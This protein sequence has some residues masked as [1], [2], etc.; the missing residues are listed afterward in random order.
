MIIDGPTRQQVLISLDS[1][2]TEII[3][4]N[5]A[6]ELSS[7]TSAWLKLTLNLDVVATTRHSRSNDLTN[8]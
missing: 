8:E 3:I 1:S 7:V 6:L 4:A 5:T 2:T